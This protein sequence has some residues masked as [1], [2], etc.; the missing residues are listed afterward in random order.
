M[1]RPAPPDASAGVEGEL[2][3]VKL[4]RDR[5]FAAV[6]VDGR[7][8]DDGECEF[9]ARVGEG[10]HPHGL[11]FGPRGRRAYLA[12][13]SSGTVEAVDVRSSSVLD[14]TDAVGTAPIGVAASR[15]G[16]YLYVTGYGDL[17]DDD[18]PGVTVLRTHARD[19]GRFEPVAHLPIG[20]GAGVVVDAGDDPW[21]ALKDDGAVVRLDGRPP[22]DVRD[23]LSVPG[24]PQDLSYAPG[25]RLLG[26][27]D[28]D[29]GSVSFVDLAERRVVA[30]VDAPNPRGGAASA[31]HDRW[32]VADTE[33]DGL[34]V[35]DLAGERPTRETR[36][37][38]GTPTA[39]VDVAPGGAH[40]A[41]DAYED[42]RVSFVDAGTLDVVARVRTG[43]TP[44]HPAF[45]ADGRR[46]YV[47]NVDDDSVAAIDTSSLR[48]PGSDPDPRLLARV[49][50]PTDSAPSSCFLTERPRRGA[51]T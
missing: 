49:D 20:K 40:V 6:D 25:Y 33:G 5:G 29:D 47:A 15:D 22:F 34:T 17:P 24:E 43:E 38:L 10:R 8:E 35:V 16:R 50:L 9:V 31:A 44:R 28:V 7:E 46:C 37:P 3:F 30:T 39:F 13:A 11:A 51:D 12:Y 32:F 23:R 4:M 21:V 26:V 14:R 36:L 27:N 18:G 1:S 42:D 48:E 41:V 2:A 45:A 19:D